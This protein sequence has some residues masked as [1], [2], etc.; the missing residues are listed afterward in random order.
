LPRKCGIAAGDLPRRK[1]DGAINGGVFATLK[2]E[3]TDAPDF[4]VV[5]AKKGEQLVETEIQR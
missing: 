5:N 1:F 3:T 2:V 4:N